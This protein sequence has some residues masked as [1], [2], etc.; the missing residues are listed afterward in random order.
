MRDLSQLLP[1]LLEIF[2]EEAE[3]HHGICG[4]VFKLYR[5][6]SIYYNESEVMLLFIQTHKPT[7]HSPFFNHPN[8]RGELWWWDGKTGS[9]EQRILFI[10]HLIENLP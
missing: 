1:M 4:F 5:E 8:Y 10:N 3:E 6:G 7:T 2:T 9:K